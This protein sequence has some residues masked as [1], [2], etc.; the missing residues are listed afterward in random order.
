MWVTFW[1]LNEDKY[2]ESEEFS[3]SQPISCCVPSRVHPF[4][5]VLDIALS[6]RRSQVRICALKPII[7]GY[8]WSLSSLPVEC[9]N[10]PFG[11]CH[12]FSFRLPLTCVWRRIVW[13]ICTRISKETTAPIFRAE[14]ETVRQTWSLAWGNDGNETTG[15]LTTS[16][17]F[18]CPEEGGSIFLRNVHLY[19]PT[20]V[21]APTHGASQSRSLLTVIS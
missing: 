12:L 3:N 21:T 13:E 8:L 9:C 19:V 4:Y 1:R 15:V 6:L 14:D 11:L 17:L 20:A 10:V 7:L 18:F 5:L 2:Y 16:G